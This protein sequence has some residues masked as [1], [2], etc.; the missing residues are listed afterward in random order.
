MSHHISKSVRVGDG[1]ASRA[2]VDD[3]LPSM[4]AGKLE[5]T[6]QAT[7]SDADVREYTR[8]R[9]HARS[10]ARNVRHRRDREAQQDVKRLRG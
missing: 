3:Q 2:A 6:G 10:Y 4:A 7:P 1:D 5:A 9:I 8:G